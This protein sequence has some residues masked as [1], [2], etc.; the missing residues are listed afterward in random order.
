MDLLSM[1]EIKAQYLVLNVQAFK[2]KYAFLFLV[3]CRKKNT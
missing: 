1:A 3:L 2:Y